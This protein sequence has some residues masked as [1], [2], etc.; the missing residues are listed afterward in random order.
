MNL[1]ARKIS[2]IQEFLS[3][4]DEE[5]VSGLEKF[6]RQ[7]KAEFIDED[8]KSMTMEQYDAE[9]DEAMKD[10]KNEQMI[11][12]AEL[13]AKIQKWNQ[14]FTGLVLPNINLNQ[15][16]N[17]TQLKRIKKLAKKLVTNIV[18]ATM[19]LQNQ[20]EIGQIEL[21]L[22]HREKEFRYLVY[23]SYKIV[24]WVNYDF[25]RIEIANI[26][27]KRQNPNKLDETL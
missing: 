25:K 24:Y 11:K 23:K 3:L 8:F 9:M 18:N 22:R 19:S 2:F 20:P 15:F 10:S 7:S 26:F 5:I 17:I 16:T 13:K 14:K 27:D 21:N 6:L 4:Q 12:A 1:E